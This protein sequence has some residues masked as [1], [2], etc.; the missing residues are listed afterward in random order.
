VE[1]NVSEGHTTTIFRV[2][3]RQIGKVAGCTEEGGKEMGHG[4]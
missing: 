4:R 3:I 2:E 1:T